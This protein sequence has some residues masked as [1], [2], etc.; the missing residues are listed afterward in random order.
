MKIF[1]IT[2]L[3]FGYLTFPRIAE[4]QN[5]DKSE[6]KVI[7]KVDFRLYDKE[8]SLENFLQP[9]EAP[10]VILPRAGSVYIKATHASGSRYFWEAERGH[11]EILVT[12]GIWTL[13]C[14]SVGYIS[15]KINWQ[16]DGSRDSLIILKKWHESYLGFLNKIPSSLFSGNPYAQFLRERS[17]QKNEKIKRYLAERCLTDQWLLLNLGA[18]VGSLH[19]LDIN[20]TNKTLSVKSGDFY[21]RW[22]YLGTQFQMAHFEDWQL[23]LLTGLLEDYYTVDF[24]SQFAHNVNL[25]VGGIFFNQTALSVYALLSTAGPLFSSGYPG[26]GVKWRQRLF[27]DPGS[28]SFWGL[29][30]GYSLSG[31][32][33]NVGEKDSHRGIIYYHRHALWGEL[34][35]KFLSKDL[36]LDLFNSEWAVHLGFQ[37]EWHRARELL[38]KSYS[39]Q[40]NPDFENWSVYLHFHFPGLFF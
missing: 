6:E 19:Y 32:Q 26:F 36:N 9:V 2:C 13:E 4:A 20:E 37:Y 14:Y 29:G 17:N 1:A 12:P 11:L 21:L 35:L 10:S 25:G 22:K 31:L 23:S 3:I 16:I 24:K 18:G 30:G 15:E 38:D 27:F 40:G 5:R 39:F 34:V 7:L 33:Y 28:R 8:E